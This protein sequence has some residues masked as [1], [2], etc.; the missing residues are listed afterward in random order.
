MP[1]KSYKLS[2]CLRNTF[3][4]EERLSSKIQIDLLFEK[5][6]YFNNFPIKVV[7][8]D[9]VFE[10]SF[11]AQIIVSVPK[12]NFK[13]AVDRNRI[14]RL[15]RESYRKN[16]SEFYNYLTAQN[17]KM[18]VGF[19]YTSNEMPDYSDVESKIV[20]ILQKIKT[21]HAKGS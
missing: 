1:L 21:Q 18:A 19:V 14:K 17:I 3:C 12:K 20:L 9:A 2:N 13:K 8:I 11:P 4:K 5:G 10:S 7:W 6:R 16:K 15:I